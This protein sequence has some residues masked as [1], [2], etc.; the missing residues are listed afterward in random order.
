MNVSSVF[1]F[2]NS[3]FSSEKSF[4]WK[5]FAKFSIAFSNAL[6][7]LT[8]VPKSASWMH[9]RLADTIFFAHFPERRILFLEIQVC[10]FIICL[11]EN[12]F[13][14]IGC[15]K[16]VNSV[17]FIYS[18]PVFGAE[19]Q[20]LSDSYFVVELT[21]LQKGKQNIFEK[22]NLLPEAV[23]YDQ[24]LNFVLLVLIQLPIISNF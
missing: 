1:K 4:N 16:K 15:R 11:S 9:S 5:T 3:I 10:Y 2:G 12:V 19:L 13:S 22:A 6:I 23:F 8:F 21:F 18:L 20:R 24:R 17:P 7:E 14:I